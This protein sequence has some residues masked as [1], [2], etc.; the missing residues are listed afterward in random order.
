MTLS[1]EQLEEGTA[2]AIDF[3]KLRKIGESGLDVVPVVLRTRTPS[4][5]ASTMSSDGC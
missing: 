1:D 2:V 5:C 4:A 3:G